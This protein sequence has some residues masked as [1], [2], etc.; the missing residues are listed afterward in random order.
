MASNSAESPSVIKRRTRDK[1]SWPRSI[2]RH[3]RKTQWKKAA[4]PRRPP[5]RSWPIGQ[6]DRGAAEGDPRARGNRRI[7]RHHARKRRAPGHRVCCDRPARAG[8]VTKKDLWEAQELAEP[9]LINPGSSQQHLGCL[10]NSQTTST[11]MGTL[12]LLSQLWVHPQLF[13][14]FC[15]NCS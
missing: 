2:G 8:C 9:I 13:S 12:G 3:F 14:C 15:R 7:P 11:V 6:A 1:F 10:F 5:C 4:D